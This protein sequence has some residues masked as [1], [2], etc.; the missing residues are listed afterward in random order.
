MALLLLN[1]GVRCR[2]YIVSWLSNLEIRSMVCLF[3]P[4]WSIKLAFLENF[5]VIIEA[6][7]PKQYGAPRLELHT[8]TRSICWGRGRRGTPVFVAAVVE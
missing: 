3:F 5:R 6:T 8:T 1:A 4:F 7:A 2:R